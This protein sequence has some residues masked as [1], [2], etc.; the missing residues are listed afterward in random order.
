MKKI[1]ICAVAI[2]IFGL[3]LPPTA[4]AAT[5]TTTTS[6]IASASPVTIN[7]AVTLTATVTGTANPAGTVT[8]D[9]NAVSIGSCTLVLSTCSITYTWS[10]RNEYPVIATYLPTSNHTTSS[11]APLTIVVTRYP[12]SVVVASSK[13]DAYLGNPLDFTITASGQGPT[14][15]GAANLFAYESDTVIGTC[16]LAAGVCVIHLA[17]STVGN[18]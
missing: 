7:T 9:V 10:A 2:V 8:F 14:P 15:T 6:L 12:S 3:F 1:S 16:T 5:K 18:H 17:A 4:F 13:P 11:S